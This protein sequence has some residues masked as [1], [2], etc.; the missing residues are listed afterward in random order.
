MHDRSR[1]AVNSIHGGCDAVH[2]DRLPEGEKTAALLIES[3]LYVTDIVDNDHL[4]FIR[5]VRNRCQV[6]WL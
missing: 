4:Y 3:G 2:S 5:A 1:E 6:S